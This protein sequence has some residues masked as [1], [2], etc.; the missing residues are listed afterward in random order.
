MKQKSVFLN[1]EAD[2]WYNRNKDNLKLVG[3]PILEAFGPIKAAG[4]ISS[5][6]EIGCGTGLRLEHLCKITGAKVFGLDPSPLSIS[7]AKSR[8]IT[9]EVGTA[10]KLPW[11]DASMD[12]VIFGF[13]LYLC[14]REDLFRIASEADRLLK[15][16][17]WLI[18]LD[19]HSRDQAIRPYKH[20][21]GVNSYKMDYSKIFTWHPGYTIFNHNITDHANRGQFTDDPNEWIATTTIRKNVTNQ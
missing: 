10:D 2:S 11:P 16:P 13:C 21:D 8:K 20:L 12:L 7:E 19:F 9:A 6:L 18:I 14:D 3:D 17:G 5:I 4:N 15:N 1:N